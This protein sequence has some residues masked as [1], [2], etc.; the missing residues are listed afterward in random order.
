MGGAFV[1]LD[2]IIAKRLG[3]GVI[4]FGSVENE[5]I[6]PKE[7]TLLLSKAEPEDFIHFGMIPEFVGRFHAIANCNELTL[8]DL[9]SILTEP[10]NAVIKQFIA[11]FDMEGVKLHFN[12][13][14]LQAIAEKAL[15]AGTGARALRMILENLMKELMFEIPSD[16]AVTEVIIEKET[17]TEKKLPLIKRTSEK[18]A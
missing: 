10:K 14:A 12:E 1:N 2:K 6:D 3:K 7:K 4:G 18:I 15:A 9:K 11:M 8:N 16:E 13:E 5:A 17:V